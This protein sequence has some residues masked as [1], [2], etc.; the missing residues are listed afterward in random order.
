MEEDVIRVPTGGIK[1]RRRR[2]E[3]LKGGFR[4]KETE[5]DVITRLKILCIKD[6]KTDV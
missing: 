3:R 6:Q 2:G 5:G 1:K 4:K